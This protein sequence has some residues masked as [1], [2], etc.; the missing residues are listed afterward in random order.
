MLGPVSKVSD[1]LGWTG[2][3]P[4]ACHEV[5][6]DMGSRP[7]PSTFRSSQMVGPGD[8]T[9]PEASVKRC[10]ILTI[11]G[12]NSSPQSQR[13][14]LRNV[15]SLCLAGPQAAVRAP[16]QVICFVR[17]VKTEQLPSGALDELS[18]SLPGNA[19]APACL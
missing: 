12:K 3:R 15:F 9:V 13:L 2:T 5:T 6:L 1:Y 19:T 14:R 17:N 10:Q 11:G 4:G 18:G 16:G 8:V 7:L